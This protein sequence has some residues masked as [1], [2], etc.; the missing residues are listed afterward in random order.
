MLYREAIKF[1]LVGA[2]AFVVDV[3]V[4]NLLRATVLED[5]PTTA[6]VISASVATIVAWIGNRAWTFRHRRN[7]RMHHEALLFFLTNGVEDQWADPPGQFDLLRAADPVYRLLGAG[8]LEAGE[9]PRLGEASFGR[10]GYYLRA[11]GHVT[12]PEYW[13]VFL[14]FADRHLKPGGGAAPSAKPASKS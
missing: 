12:D 8:G 9:S 1:G 13:K 4:M 3:G 6:K 7:R 10:L 5:K 14:D 2:L 11:G